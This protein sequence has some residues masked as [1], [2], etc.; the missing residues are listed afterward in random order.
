MMYAIFGACGAV[1][2]ALASELAATQKP[3]RVVGRSTLRL[4]RLF[5]AYEPLV[6]YV[7]ANLADGHSAAIAAQGVETIF[8]TV[9]VP[10]N[11]FELHPQLTRNAVEAAQEASV[12][13]FI[14][15]SDV[16]PYGTPQSELVSEA[17][18]RD[19]NTFKGRM[20]KKQ[21]DIVL[22]ADRHYELRTL[23][24]R[25]PDFYGPEATK[26][27]THP[28]FTAALRGE[29]ANLI[30]PIDMPREFIYV[31][32]LARVLIALADHP[33]AYGH[34]WNVGG[35]DLITIRRFADTAYAAAGGQKAKLLVLNTTMLRFLGFFDPIMRESVEMHY[36]WNTPILLDDKRLR[37]L[38]PE[39]RKTSY[40]EGIAATLDA[41]KS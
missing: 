25:P 10:Y 37:K 7:E 35:P 36:L 15:V 8:Y 21:E 3:F 26:S 39:M 9:G 12:R 29:R 14:H 19:A 22:S 40:E 33:E 31:P 20:R 32:D 6:E 16:Y 23:V 1:G 30:G 13:R 24:V 34:A 11:Q 17:H 28:I 5:S 27:F 4:K 18:P 2:R 41:L 38:L